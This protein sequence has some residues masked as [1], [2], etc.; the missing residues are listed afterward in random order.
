MQSHRP[1]RAADWGASAQSGGRRRE[2][3][4][5]ERGRAGRQGAGRRGEPRGPGS[6]SGRGEGAGAAAAIETLPGGTVRSLLGLSFSLV[7]GSYTRNPTNLTLEALEGF[8]SGVQPEPHFA[9]RRRT[10]AHSRCLGERILRKVEN[11]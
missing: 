4:G 10:H 8:V 7:L 1:S 3:A 2:A 6:A 9:W 5:G 11:A